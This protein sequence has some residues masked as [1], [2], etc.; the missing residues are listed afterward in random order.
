MAVDWQ[1][2]WETVYQTRTPTEVSWHQDNP[3]RS[4]DLIQRTGVSPTAPML[5][6]GGGA[7]RLVEYLLAQGFTDLTVLDVS[8]VALQQAR[9]RLGPAADR[10]TWVE[11]DITMF[12]PSRRF[13][14][15]HDRAVFHFLTDATDRQRY[16]AA[17]RAAL[18]PQGDVV[19]AT[20]ALEGP[21]RCSGLPVQRYS[22]ATLGAE[23]GAGFV[24][25]GEEREAH[26]TPAGA[27]QQFQYCWF[28]ADA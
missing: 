21:E 19:I 23:L 22:A 27:V 4:R 1:R 28:Q 8:A 18:A 11:A 24:L 14:V 17:L 15:W 5:D 2:H 20:F 7:S 12:V 9:E 3:A 16:V 13:Q 25:M 6:V 26:V 10:V